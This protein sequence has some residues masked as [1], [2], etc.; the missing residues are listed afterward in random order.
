MI[1]ERNFV[2]FCPIFPKYVKLTK[3]LYL[4]VA[5]L[6][7]SSSALPP[8]ALPPLLPP[9]EGDQP[10]HG[11]L[12]PG[13]H[14]QGLPV[15]RQHQQH[16]QHNRS[17]RRESTA[18]PQQ[19]SFI[20]H[21]QSQETPGIVRITS[22]HHPHLLLLIIFIVFSHIKNIS[23]IK[24]IKNGSSRIRKN[25]S[26][27]LKKDSRAAGA[28]ER[29]KNQVLKRIENVYVICGG[30]AVSLMH[31]VDNSNNNTML[32]REPFMSWAW[33]NRFWGLYGPS[34]LG[35][36]SRHSNLRPP[37]RSIHTF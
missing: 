13:R 18:E 26:W 8:P 22:G 7:L 10:R 28:G 9:A 32:A 5:T 30:L 17:Q 19:F 33:A 20:A 24:I 16:Q 23:N 12:L 15:S 4:Q 3:L 6:G 34:R 35:S 36:S 14:R 25:S 11:D 31:A 2:Y 27:R 37:T 29:I 1:S 21:W